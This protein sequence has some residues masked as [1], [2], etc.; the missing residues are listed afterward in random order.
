MIEKM[1]KEPLNIKGRSNCLS[2]MSEMDQEFL[3]ENRGIIEPELARIE[4]FESEGVQYAVGPQTKGWIEDIRE[5][6]K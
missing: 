6:L 3:K 1:Q 5:K 2:I 4:S